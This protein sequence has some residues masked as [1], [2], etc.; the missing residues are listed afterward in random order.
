MRLL[1]SSLSALL[2]GIAACRGSPNLLIATTDGVRGQGSI[3]Y[4]GEQIELIQMH[5][6]DLPANERSNI[7]IGFSTHPAMPLD[8]ITEEFVKRIAVP[9]T[10]Y[11]SEPLNPAYF[12][13]AYDFE[14]ENGR[15]REVY[16]NLNGW[17]PKGINAF[18]N[19]GSDHGAFK[20]PCSI[21]EF[22]QVFGKAKIVRSYYE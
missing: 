11:Y 18:S 12:V 7:M 17:P 4:M 2:L 15:L 6:G 19:I 8:S 9:S 22:E 10:R 20:L 16:V 1:H 5:P 13:D 21:S 3:S 14:F